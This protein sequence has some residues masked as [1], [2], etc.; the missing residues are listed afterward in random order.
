MTLF[1][2]FSLISSQIKFINLFL[3][4]IFFKRIVFQLPFYNGGAL[5]DRCSSQFSSKKKLVEKCSCL[6][7]TRLWRI[8]LNTIIFIYTSWMQ[9]KGGQ[10]IKRKLDLPAIIISLEIHKVMKKITV[11]KG[12]FRE[13]HTR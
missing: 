1:S 7:Q 12:I 2:F 3:S 11:L 13:G 9:S 10:V 5:S 6:C 4:F 8:S